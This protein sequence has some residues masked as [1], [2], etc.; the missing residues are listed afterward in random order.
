MKNNREKFSSSF[1]AALRRTAALLA[2]AAFVFGSVSCSEIG[3]KIDDA[4]NENQQDDTAAI[5]QAKR[6]Y[7]QGVTAY[8]NWDFDEAKRCFAESGMYGNASDFIEAIEKYEKRYFD[9]VEAME[10]RDYPTALA[11]FESMP[12][13]QNCQEYIDRISELKS[14]Y[15][16]GVE[17]Y[18]SNQFREAREAFANS[19]GYLHSDEYIENIDEMVERYNRGIAL[20]DQGNYLEAIPEFRGINAPFEDTEAKIRFCM[21]NIK[22]SRVSLEHFIRSYNEEQ[23]GEAKIEAGNPEREFT[24]RDSLGILFGGTTDENGWIETMTIEFPSDVRKALGDEGYKDAVCRCIHA[25]NPYERSFE[26]LRADIDTYISSNGGEYGI[27][28][29]RTVHGENSSRLIEIIRYYR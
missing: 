7:D 5:E 19:G 15:E 4:I 17:L 18:N 22:F 2:A 1:I 9:A 14:E 3:Q 6:L 12:K 26:E 20:I 27:M 23:N 16:H 24:L 13:Y 11:A 29:I 21:D 28:W 25:L 10:R 8:E